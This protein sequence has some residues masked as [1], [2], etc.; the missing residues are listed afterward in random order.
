MMNDEQKNEERAFLL[1]IIHI[2]HHSSF[3]IHHS[4]FIILFLKICYR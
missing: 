2:I 1:F 3:I 4:A